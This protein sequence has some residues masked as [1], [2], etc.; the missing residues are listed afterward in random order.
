MKIV[1]IG[2]TGLIGSKLVATLRKHDPDVTAASPDTGVN[3]MTGEGLA[4][5]LIGADVVV[6]VSNAPRFEADA[7]MDFFTTSTRN[8]LSASQAADVSHYVALSVVG[9]ERLLKSAYFRAKLAQEDLITTGPLPYSIVRATQFFEFVKS[10]A[11]AATTGGTVRLSTASIQPIAADDVASAVGHIAVNR[12]INGTVE[13]AGPE[14]F[15]LAE[16]IRHGLAAK[17]D[18]REVTD[19]PKAPY[20]GALLQQRTLLPGPGAM[21]FTTRFN[22]W[23][24]QSVATQS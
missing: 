6:D 21:I 15:A 24:T 7:V 12:P 11:D 9:T 19:D 23:I 10:I 13:V 22:D 16:L 1:V 4:E 5:A 2:G 17:G 18:S 20:F 3:S 14:I 8:L